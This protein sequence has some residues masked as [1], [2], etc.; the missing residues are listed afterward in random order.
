MGLF[1]QNNSILPE[2]VKAPQPKPFVPTFETPPTLVNPYGGTERL[3]PAYF[4]TE[5]TALA[6][7][8]RFGGVSVFQK[9]LTFGGGYTLTPPSAGQWTVRFEDYAGKPVEI[10]AGLLADYFVRGP[11][12]DYPGWAEQG[13]REALRRRGVY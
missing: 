5:E 7:M 2:P 10:N 9:P 13:V 11:E 3:N 12:A 1:S 8:D 6:I 4:A